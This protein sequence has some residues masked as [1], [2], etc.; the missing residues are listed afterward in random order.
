[1]KNFMDWLYKDATLYLERKYKKYQNFTIAFEEYK[2]NPSSKN[3]PIIIDKML[4]EGLTLEYNEETII[5][6][7]DKYDIEQHLVKRYLKEAFKDE[8]I[9]S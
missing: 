8:A 9:I 7:A 1:M 5:Y 3:S 2:S 6:L 4:E